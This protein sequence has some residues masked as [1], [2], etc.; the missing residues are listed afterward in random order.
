M[1][2][3]VSEHFVNYQIKSYPKIKVRH[4]ITLYSCHE[5]ELRFR[6]HMAETRQRATLAI[7]YFLTSTKIDTSLICL[8]TRVNGLA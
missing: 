1:Q 8:K 7:S 3:S 4:L 6:V 5:V 2:I